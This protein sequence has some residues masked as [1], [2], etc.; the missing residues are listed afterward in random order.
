MQKK[1]GC[2]DSMS[3]ESKAQFMEFIERDQALRKEWPTMTEEE[4]A[5]IPQRSKR[6]Q[7]RMDTQV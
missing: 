6:F 5:K 3:P 7:D 4:R 2:I 1:T